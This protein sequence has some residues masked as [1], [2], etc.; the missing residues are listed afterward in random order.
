M[1]KGDLLNRIESLD[2]SRIGNMSLEV[3]PTLT[4]N[5]DESLVRALIQMIL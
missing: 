1:S 3:I 2:A 4:D 5:F